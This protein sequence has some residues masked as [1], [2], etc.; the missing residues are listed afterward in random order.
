MSC[1]MGTVVIGAP[2]F[3]SFHLLDR[4]RR[5]LT[6]R[7]HDVTTLFGDTTRAHFWRLQ[8][9]SAH[10]LVHAPPDRMRAPLAEF[11][12]CEAQRR[13][14]REGTAAHRRTTARVQQDLA[15]LLPS[16]LRWFE[17]HRPDLLLLPGARSAESHLLHFVARELGVRVLWIG[18]GLLPHTLQHDER[19]RDGDASIVRRIAGDYRDARSDASFTASCLAHLLAR[20][21]PAA[22]S[23]R[24]LRPPRWRDLVPTALAAARREGWHGAKTA[25]HGWR[26]ALPQRRPAPLGFEMPEAPFATVLLQ[27]RDDERVRLD[28]NHPPDALQLVAAART[29]ADAVDRGVALA[30]VLPPRGLH[31]RDV[32]AIAALPRVHLLPGDAAVEAAA[33]G[34]ATFTINHPLAVAALLARSLVLHCGRA[35]Y[36]L[37]G[38]TF[39]GPSASFVD[40]LGTALRD[41]ADTLR[42]RLLTVLLGQDH[43]WCSPTHPDHNGILGLA[44]A[45]EEALGRRSP[46]GARVEHRSGPPWP[47]AAPFEP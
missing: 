35:L 9:Q 31:H 15:R 45:I 14:V 23:R 10:E 24:E 7:A 18:P 41:D 6:H 8:G 39:R 20:A 37:G 5:E 32:A 47:L 34:M 29:A 28:A 43:L 13:G 16:C 25:W 38:V 40:V 44:N 30:V 11:A 3:D 42:E 2:E 19:G 4:L 46:R 22:L 12:A 33:T 17:D 26:A 27:D 36:G 21:E 1:G